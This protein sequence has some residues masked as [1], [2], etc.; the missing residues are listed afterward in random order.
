M[1]SE[2]RERQTNSGRDGRQKTGESLL[3]S[4]CLSTFFQL[5]CVYF[6]S[7]HKRLLP[8]TALQRIPPSSPFIPLWSFLNLVTHNVYIYNIYIYIDIIIPSPSIHHPNHS[9]S[10]FLLH[11][12]LV[13]SPFC[14]SSLEEIECEIKKSM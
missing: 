7:Q 14:I 9:I 1:K 8:F 10:L 3:H 11:L 13:S 12:L 2:E 5:Q 6:F 4:C